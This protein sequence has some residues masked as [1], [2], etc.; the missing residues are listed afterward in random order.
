MPTSLPDPTT[1]R[2]QSAGVT[3]RALLRF[4]AIPFTA[5]SPDVALWLRCGRSAPAL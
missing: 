2:R 4:L 5:L 3:R 1:T